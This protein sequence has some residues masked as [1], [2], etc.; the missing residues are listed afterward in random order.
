MTLLLSHLMP[1][2]IVYYMND[3]REFDYAWH[4]ALNIPWSTT[5]IVELNNLEVGVSVALVT[6][7]AIGVFGLNLVLSRVM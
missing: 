4:Q 7:C 1:L 2:L 5:A 6:L 3:Y